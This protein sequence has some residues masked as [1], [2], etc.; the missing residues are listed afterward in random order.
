MWKINNK[1][2]VYEL[3]PVEV[4]ELDATDPN[5]NEKKRVSMSVGGDTV[6]IIPRFSN[7]DFLLAKQF[8]VGEEREVIEFPNGGIEPGESYEDAAKRELNEEVGYTGEFKYLGSFTPLVGLVDLNVHVYLCNNITPVDNKLKQDS[9]ESITSERITETELENM[10][11]SGKIF[12][13]YAL[14]AYMLYKLNK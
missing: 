6:L 10:I 13:G 12:D 14:S 1:K 4:A 5:G 7:S 11:T 2:I 9:Y 3:G 8:R